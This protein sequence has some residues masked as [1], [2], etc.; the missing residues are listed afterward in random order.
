MRRVISPL[1]S[2]AM[3][4]SS[5]ALRRLQQ[6]EIQRRTVRGQHLG[7]GLW[8][9]A[10]EGPTSILNGTLLGMGTVAYST[11]ARHRWASTRL[12]GIISMRRRFRLRFL[13]RIGKVAMPLTCIGR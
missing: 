11:T 6:W 1:I 13:G 10:N 9:A 7:A 4:A 5:L 3:V 8:G 12:I 2:G